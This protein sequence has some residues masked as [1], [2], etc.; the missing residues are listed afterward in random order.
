M[1]RHIATV[2]MVLFVANAA[3]VPSAGAQTL[4]Q[5]R[6]ACRRSDG[7]GICA[8]Y[9]R[10]VFD[11]MTV[12]GRADSLLPSFRRD[13]GICFQGDMTGAQAVQAFINWANE[14]PVAWQKPAFLGVV[15]ALR[16]TFPCN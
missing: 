4:Q 10:G 14:N 3:L 2:L 13:Y 1:K 16:E 7:A 9:V 8:A 5:M 12:I 11:F 15:I 6:E